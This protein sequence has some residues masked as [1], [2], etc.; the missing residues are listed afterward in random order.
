[1]VLLQMIVDGRRCLGHKLVRTPPKKKL[2]GSKTQKSEF[3]VF[4][5]FYLLCNLW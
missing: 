4:K 3:Y 5:R 1:M 2:L